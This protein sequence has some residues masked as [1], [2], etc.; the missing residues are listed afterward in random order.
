M[1]TLLIDNYD[2]FTFNLVQLLAGMGEPTLVL[3]NDDLDGWQ[4]LDWDAIDRI[5]VSPGPGS[6]AVPEDLGL[7]RDAILSRAKP[8]L[9]VCL[10]HQALCHLSGGTVRRAPEPVHGR[11][12]RIRHGQ[13]DLFAGIPDGFVATRYHSLVVTDVPDEIE[14]TAWS[15][16][17]L[18]MAV[19]HRDWPAWGVQFHPE[20][21]GSEYG[22]RLLDNFV[23]LSGEASGPRTPRPPAPLTPPRRRSNPGAAGATRLLRT[24]W[25]EL[26]TAPDPAAAMRALF[27]NVDVA[28]W[29]DTLSLDG[30]ST[31]LSYVGAGCGLGSETVS[32][33]VA[34]GFVRALSPVGS[35]REI[36]GSIQDHLAARLAAYRAPD[37]GPVPF[38]LGYVGWL[39]YELR[40]LGGPPHRR[41]A[42]HPDAFLVLADRMLVVDHASSQAWLAAFDVEGDTGA[43]AAWLEEST[44]LLATVPPEPPLQLP[45]SVDL[46]QV[47]LRHDVS[48]YLDRIARCQELIEAGE[49]YELCLTNQLSIDASVEPFD[50]FRVLRTLNPAPFATF[51]RTPGVAVVGAS[52]ERF[53]TVDDGVMVSKPMKGTRRRGA[54]PVEDDLLREDLAS[55]VKERAENLMITDLVRSDLGSVSRPGSVKVDRLFGVETYPHVHQLVSTVSAVAADGVSLMDIVSATFPGGS[56]TGAPKRRS[57]ELLDDFEGGPRGIY[58]GATGFLSFDE[59]LDLSMVIRTAV[60]T[61]GEVTVGAGGAITALSDPEEEVA[62]M[63]LKGAAVLL[64][65]GA[66]ARLRS[67]AT[68]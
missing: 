30:R 54:D 4:A 8:L 10:G 45:P 32:Y 50:L 9:G 21:I 14:C 11:T 51:F 13:D 47:A 63:Q 40:D 38:N 55:S 37:R 1:T 64:A 61:P 26:D 5:V 53:L 18:L 27:P 52:P 29:I 68:G 12:S 35:A 65:I 39:G 44:R 23:A 42:P 59:R 36:S 22:A 60:V 34:D 43:A 15:D 28:F 3:N 57:T 49:S 67:R 33:R 48:A 19:R 16:D 62:E 56:M 25:V 17:G 41:R 58:S 46:P 7:S 6:P 31:P 66:A 24:Q 20:S 2:S